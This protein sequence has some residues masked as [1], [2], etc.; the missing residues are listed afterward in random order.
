MDILLVAKLLQNIRVYK[1]L[2]FFLIATNGMP[3]NYSK[4]GINF[5]WIVIGY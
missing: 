2:S 1:Y 5:L 3:F 4:F